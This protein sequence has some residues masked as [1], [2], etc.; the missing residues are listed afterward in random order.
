MGCTHYPFLTI[1]IAKVL[2][3]LR[4]VKTNGGYRYKKLLSK[5][6]ILIDPAL[7]T[8]QELYNCLKDQKLLNNEVSTQNADFF[9]GIPNKNI[10]SIITEDAG[11]RFTYHYKY[12]RNSNENK[13]FVMTVPFCKTNI[14]EDV[15]ERIKQQIPNVFD[16]IVRSKLN[17]FVDESIRLK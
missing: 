4:K 10:P 15:S 17:E 14:S 9:I 13:Q 1:E 8:A 3:E 11:Q 16:L 12:S 5:N 2:K 6:V 7:E